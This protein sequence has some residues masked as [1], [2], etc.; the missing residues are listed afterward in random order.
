MS[1]QAATASFPSSVC[2][3]SV[4]PA[5]GSLCGVV[6]AADLNSL[7]TWLGTAVGITISSWLADG[8]PGDDTGSS[9]I[10][11]F[12]REVFLEYWVPPGAS[13]MTL[14]PVLPHGMALD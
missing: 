8:V 6:G 11:L 2:A 14:L 1:P 9:C 10:N 13:T 5:R 7:N 4:I 12:I 3:D